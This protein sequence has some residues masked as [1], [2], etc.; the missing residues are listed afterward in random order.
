MSFLTP[1]QKELIHRWWR[2]LDVQTGSANGSGV[3]AS[4]RLFPPFDRGHRARL[5]RAVSLADIEQEESVYRLRERLGPL[6][7]TWLER[8]D[9]PW[10]FL[11]AG[12]VALVKSDDA[13][14]G[15]KPGPSLAA[16]LGEAAAPPGGSA[17]FSEIRFQRMMRADTSEEFYLQLRRALRL[18]SAPVDVAGL[19]DDMLAWCYERSRPTQ[20][21]SS[22]RYRWTRDYY[23]SS[24]DRKL[25]THDDV[26]A[27]SSPAVNSETLHD[28]VPPAASAHRLPTQQPQSRRP[29][30][31][32]DGALRRRQPPPHLVAV[33]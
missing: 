4:R 6:Q 33:S 14:G 15:N 13:T 19:A 22:M 23:L 11:L 12:A 30:T 17:P 8:N 1:S 20:T 24:E 27:A 25:A 2:A 31:A 7:S 32:E 29:P 3:Q 28:S 9:Q 18:V 21:A 16:R 26:L 10:L 5:R